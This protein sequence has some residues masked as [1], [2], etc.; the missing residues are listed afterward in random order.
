M[1]NTRARK[2][3]S[4]FLKT[5]ENELTFIARCNLL[6]DFLHAH[7]LKQSLQLMQFSKLIQVFYSFIKKYQNNFVAAKNVQC[8]FL[9]S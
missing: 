4:N 1:N 9:L 6:F 2:V 3:C 8:F 7:L 5:L